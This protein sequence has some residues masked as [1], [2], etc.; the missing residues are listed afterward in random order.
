MVDI[1]SNGNSVT[2]VAVTNVDYCELKSPPPPHAPPSFPVNQIPNP[3]AGNLKASGL[4]DTAAVL[5]QV[6]NLSGFHCF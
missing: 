1:I 5:K 4:H 6:E 3:V 2:C